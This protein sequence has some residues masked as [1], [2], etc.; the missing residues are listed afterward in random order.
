[1]IGK[2]SVA[3]GLAHEDVEVPIVWDDMQRVPVVA[4]AREPCVSGVWLSGSKQELSAPVMSANRALVLGGSSMYPAIQHRS[5]AHRDKVAGVDAALHLLEE[6]HRH[7]AEL[8]AQPLVSGGVQVLVPPQRR[9]A[10]AV[11][12]AR[13]LANHVVALVM[14][15]PNPGGHR[16]GQDP[17][18]ALV[19]PARVEVAH[20]PPRGRQHVVDLDPGQAVQDRVQRDGVGDDRRDVGQQPRDCGHRKARRS[21]AVDDRT[22]LGRI[23]QA[24]DGGHRR[25]MVVAGRL[26]ERPVRRLEIDRRPP[27]D[28]PHVP[29]L[30]DQGVDDRRLHRSAEDVRAHAGAVDEQHRRALWVDAPAH[31]QHRQPPAVAGLELVELLAYRFAGGHHIRGR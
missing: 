16:F 6:R 31:V 11:G 2:T 7:E 17:G 21:L 26:V 22:H 13:H 10:G 19:A 1:M 8:V 18:R 27:V 3:G 14:G 4:A 20:H 23:R 30:R 9:L 29:A 5:V 24:L 15:Q 28:Q 12:E 25:R